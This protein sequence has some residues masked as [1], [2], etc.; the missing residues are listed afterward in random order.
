MGDTVPE[1]PDKPVFPSHSLCLLQTEAEWVREGKESRVWPL[2]C[3]LS[4]DDTWALSLPWLFLGIRVL[5]S[6]GSPLGLFLLI[7]PVVHQSCIFFNILL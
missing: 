7:L 2:R 6:C 3:I 5:G 4:A 1:E